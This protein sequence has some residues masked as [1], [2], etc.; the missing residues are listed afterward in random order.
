MV[1]LVRAWREL[2]ISPS[3]TRNYLTQSSAQKDKP[4]L[5]QKNLRPVYL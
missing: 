4:N 5:T 2:I 3:K 1:V